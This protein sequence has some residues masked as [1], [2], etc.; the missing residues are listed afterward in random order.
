MGWLSRLVVA[1]LPLVP[2][3]LVGRVASR[4][5]AGET[6]DEA[7]D[8]V[9][10]LNGE[11]A[12]ATLDLLG[13]A[14]DDRA[15]TE[16]AVDEYVRIF[17]AIES[18]GLDASVSIKLTLVGLDIDEAFCRDN[19]ERIAETAQAH[20]NFLRIDMEDH[21]THDATFRIYQELQARYG[22]LGVVLQS[23]MRRI[24][25][26]ID[27]LPAEGANVRLCKGIYIEPRRVAWKG[28]DTV[29]ENFLA[30]LEKML[31]QGVYPAI[32][33]HD[34]FLL[35]GAVRLLDRFGLGRE[36]Y[37]FQ[38]LLGVES[39]LRRIL[40]ERGHRMRVYVPYG[41]DWYPYSVRR[42]RE[43]PQVAGHVMKAIVA[44][45]GL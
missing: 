24:L 22:N 12:M 13:E 18:R 30:A 8:V 39:E 20:G 36:D 9:E 27:S 43:N 44:R 35:A 16:K 34:E 31:R 23:Y 7:L 45:R 37:E 11:G 4:Y 3:L 17:D 38:M 6:L 14:V 33:T 5:V 1:G 2:K 21:P 32:A 28:Y 10:R 19:V 41:V 25:S 26:D 40:I 15:K 42:M 29:R